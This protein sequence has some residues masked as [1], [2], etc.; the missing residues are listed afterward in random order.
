M[1]KKPKAVDLPL[2]TNKSDVESGNKRRIRGKAVIYL[3][4]IAAMA[5]LGRDHL[6]LPPSEFDPF[7]DLDTGALSSLSFGIFGGSKKSGKIEWKP[8]GEEGFECGRFEVPLNHLNTSFGATASLSVARLLA[9]NRKQR[10]GSVYVNP[11][12]PGGSGV[13]FL[14]RAGRSL[15]KILDDRY[16]IVSWDP[17]GVNETTPRVTCFD[18]QTAQDLFLIHTAFYTPLETRII[19]K[20]VNGP[21]RSELDMELLKDQL[22]IV[23]AQS[24][25]LGNLC[26]EVSQEKSKDA[27]GFWHVGTATVVR[28]LEAL[29]REIDGVGEPINFIGYS[30]GTAIGSYLVNMFPHRVGRVVIDGVVDPVVWS[31]VHVHE[32]PKLDFVDTEKDY[33]N[34]IKACVE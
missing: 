1:I 2:P 9:K 15:S 17:R 11:G 34:F 32:W 23:D 28:D 25:A 16:D 27:D 31:Q 22:K 6:P 21:A 10:V 4:A 14:F 29:A 24:E 30:Y 33:L 20:T 26:W 19:T 8:C 13:N 18:S 3:A 5:F 12:G 7:S